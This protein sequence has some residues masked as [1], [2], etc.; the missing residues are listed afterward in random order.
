MREAFG[1]MKID[2]DSDT[3][4][5]ESIGKAYGRGAGAVER[6]Q[7]W[8]RKNDTT[9]VRINKAWDKKPKRIIKKKVNRNQMYEFSR[10]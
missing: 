8:N 9:P 7:L 3:D 2:Q 5:L 1:A 10:H 6:K 4:L